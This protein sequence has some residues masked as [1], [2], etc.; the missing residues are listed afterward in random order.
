MTVGIGLQTIGYEATSDLINRKRILTNCRWKR[1]RWR[2]YPK[3][4]IVSHLINGL[5]QKPMR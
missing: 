2:K 5:P 1:S 4:E 3:I